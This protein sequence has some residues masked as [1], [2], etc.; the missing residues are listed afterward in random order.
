MEKKKTTDKKVEGTFFIRT[1]P[2]GRWYVFHQVYRN[3]KA[4]QKALPKE[5]YEALGFQLH[6]SIAE[7]RTSCKELNKVR[8]EEKQSIRRAILKSKEV[9]SLNE[10]FFP[11][12][13]L[14]LFM[15][16]LELENQGSE[17]HLQKSFSVFKF[18]QAMCIKLKIKPPEYRDQQKKIFNYF[19][20]KKVSVSYA[21]RII[22]MTNTWGYFQCRMSGQFFEPIPTIKG[23]TRER[24]A[25]AQ[26]T[27]V[28]KNTRLGVRE[29]SE[30]LTEDALKKLKDKAPPALYN[31]LHL[32]VYL[33]LRPE[34]AI[35]L[36]DEE[37]YKLEDRDGLSILWVYQ[38]KLKSVAKDKRWKLIPL[39]LPEQQECLSIIASGEFKKCS[40]K[41]ARTFLPKGTTFYGGRKNFIDMML[42]YGQKLEDIS[43]W[44]GHTSLDTSWKHYK[45]KKIINFVPIKKLRV[46]S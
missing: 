44:M 12:Q 25:D 30:P 45:N 23:N 6:W 5:S 33:G 27:K 7:A 10:Y 46:V 9:K 35:S 28:G 17:R 29:Q 20:S 36:H 1:R 41:Y 31:F 24:I 19:V 38:S 21:K 8:A 11:T 2:S 18:V 40:Y 4:I 43:M 34:E 32:T 39:I 3:G 14:V 16:K 15:E 37:S 13:L 42:S 26:A 22:A